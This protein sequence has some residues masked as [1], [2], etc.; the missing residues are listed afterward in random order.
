MSN[1]YSTLIGVA[2]VT[3]LARIMCFINGNLA[4]ELG[5]LFEWNAKLWGRRYRGIPVLDDDAQVDRL[6]YIFA[7]SVKENLVERP[8]RWPGAHC[9]RALTRSE[10]R[11]GAWV[12]R[13]A[14]YV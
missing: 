14:L 10:L 1:H 8:E 9:A 6:R 3:D 7:N 11:R 12:D 4:K 5:G 2:D 13:S